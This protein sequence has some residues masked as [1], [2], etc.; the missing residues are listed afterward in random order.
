MASEDYLPFKDYLGLSDLYTKLGNLMNPSTCRCNGNLVSG[1]CSMSSSPASEPESEFSLGL[2][3]GF[4]SFDP[5]D[6]IRSDA[7]EDF[8]NNGI[9]REI[10]EVD[11]LQL[12]MR[13][14]DQ[15]PVINTPLVEF[16][17]M[18]NQ[19]RNSR[20]CKK[21]KVKSVCVFCKNNGEQ[22]AV[23]SSHIL[24]DE[25]GRVQCPVLRKYTCPLCGVSGDAAHTIRYCPKSNPEITFSKVLT[26]P[27]LSTGKPNPRSLDAK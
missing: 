24:K 12:K 20:N 1:C 2:Y 8:L 9:E 3:D 7:H 21:S 14:A 11:Q 16:L 26:S 4:R 18:K 25:A 17:E 27:H 19:R 13:T 23:Y 6:M 15:G 10:D 22:M 5:L